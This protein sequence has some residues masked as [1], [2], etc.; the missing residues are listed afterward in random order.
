MLLCDTRSI[1][2]CLYMTIY[3]YIFV[4]RLTLRVSTL[5]TYIFLYKPV[6]QHLVKRFPKT[7]TARRTEAVGAELS[8]STCQEPKF[9][10]MQHAV[11]D[12]RIKIRDWGLRLVVCVLVRDLTRH[13]DRPTT[14]VSAS[15]VLGFIGL[16]KGVGLVHGWDLALGSRSVASSRVRSSVL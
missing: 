1:L 3:N 13:P 8:M 16:N 5:L 6:A 15:P 4:R 14:T 10:A 11:Q 9:C 7:C 12:T 2:I